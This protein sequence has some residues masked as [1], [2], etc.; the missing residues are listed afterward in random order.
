MFYVLEL[1]LIGL[2]S[3]YIYVNRVIM[4]IY[5]LGGAWASLSVRTSLCRGLYRGYIKSAG[6]MYKITWGYRNPARSAGKV[7]VWEKRSTLLG[8]S[9]VG[10]AF[11]LK[12][13]LTLAGRCTTSKLDWKT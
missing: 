12:G 11:K 9:H 10:R 8:I 3:G 13:L 7:T 4:H 2:T 6:T 1:F 5:I